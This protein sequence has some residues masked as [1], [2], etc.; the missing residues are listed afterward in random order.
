[1]SKLLENSEFRKMNYK[2]KKVMM[3][4]ELASTQNV[5]QMYVLRT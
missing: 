3:G 2:V 4:F 1:M 5:D